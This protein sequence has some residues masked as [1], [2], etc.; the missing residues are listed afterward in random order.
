MGGERP[1]L[2]GN[3]QACFGAS[4]L[5]L[6]LN[7]EALACE[8][9]GTEHTICQVGCCLV[10]ASMSDSICAGLQCV[11]LGCFFYLY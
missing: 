9:L 5:K 6:L 8:L 2:P 1:A 10:L 7:S 4:K 11:L 3:A